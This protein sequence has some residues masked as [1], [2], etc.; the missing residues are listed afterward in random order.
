[1]YDD[2]IQICIP[3]ISYRNAPDDE[4]W[5]KKS[6]TLRSELEGEYGT[7]FEPG[8]IGFGSASPAW[9]GLLDLGPWPY[10]AT[11]LYVFF[12]GKEI[13]E[14]LDA[15]REIGK[16][17][18]SFH[19]RK[20]SLN[21]S[22]AAILAIENIA[23]ALGYT[24]HSIQLV[25]YRRMTYFDKLEGKEDPGYLTTIGNAEE[26]VTNITIHV[27]QIIADDKHFRVFV[28]GDNVRL[29]RVENP[30]PLV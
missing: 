22:G 23:C 1:M 5:N 2:K 12:K 11:A 15:W 27:F 3:D 20:P 30:R 14:N 25:G 7:P 17:I 26:R 6:E 13:L 8:S 16:K 21:R 19:K 9:L 29:L 18:T 10:V 4:E 28:E 24:P